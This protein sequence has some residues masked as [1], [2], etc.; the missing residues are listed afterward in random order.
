M[1][2]W[3]RFPALLYVILSALCLFPPLANAGEPPPKALRDLNPDRPGSTTSA[4]TI[5][6]GHFEIEV[7]A[8]NYSRL[9]TRTS[10]AKST[11][12]QIS[13]ANTNIRV[14]LTNISEFSIAWIPYQ[15]QTEDLTGSPKQSLSGVG[16]V[17]IRY[18][19]NVLGNE[20]GSVAW[21]FMPGV[22][23]PTNSGGL[24][25]KK[26][27]PT[28]MLPLSV[29]L[30]TNWNVS[31]TPEFDVRSNSANGNF[32]TEFISPITVDRHLTDKYDGYFEYVVHSGDEQGTNAG[33]YVGLGGSAKFTQDLQLDIGCTFGVNESTPSYNPFAGISVRF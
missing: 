17:N 8:L 26:L 10:D 13:L 12:T 24:G 28:L 22:K 21:A 25:N 18:K 14:G 31:F 2:L 29:D 19:Q 27:E 5:D 20:G 16:D 9:T 15:T 30:S 4:T 6:V 11:T 3:F 7:E 23:L 32:H 1:I 33:T